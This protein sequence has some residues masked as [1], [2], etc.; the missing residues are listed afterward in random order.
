MKRLVIV[1]GLMIVFYGCSSQSIISNWNNNQIEIDG[2]YKDWGKSISYYEDERIGFGAV[3]D[4]KYLY[5]CLYSKDQPTIMKMMMMGL[6]IWLSPIDGGEKI[7]IK[8]PIRGERPQFDIAMRDR[9]KDRKNENEKIRKRLAELDELF[10]VNKDGFSLSSVKKYDGGDG[11]IFE[12]TY[13]DYQ[14]VYEIR[15]PLDTNELFPVLESYPG[16]QI[17]INIETNEIDRKQMMGNRSRPPMSAGAGGRMPP[18][19]G[20]GGGRGPGGIGQRGAM[21]DMMSKFE[22]ETIVVLSKEN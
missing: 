3:N 19:G 12:P 18:G 8:Y 7:G 20:M 4:S 16:E 5:L 2:N 15:I 14:F 22:F 10:I 17:E 13:E 1:I 9:N 21:K 6:N 11:F